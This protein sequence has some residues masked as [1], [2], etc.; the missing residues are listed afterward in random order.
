LSLWSG[1]ALSWGSASSNR[2]LYGVDA[3]Q[4]GRSGD[5]QY[6]PGAGFTNLAMNF[7]A[8]YRIGHGWSLSASTA[9]GWLPTNPGESPIVRNRTYV[10]ANALIS[11][12]F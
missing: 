11:Y 4:G 12:R 7:G 6:S 5:A 8:N 2:T 9:L 3:A 1:P 10:R